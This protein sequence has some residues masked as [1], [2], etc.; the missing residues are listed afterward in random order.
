MCK[1]AATVLCQ[2]SA[3]MSIN[4][5]HNFATAA[6]PLLCVPAQPDVGCIVSLLS[7]AYLFYT[8]FTSNIS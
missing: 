3:S 2:V 4:C 1:L 6:L 8:S 5:L 7:L